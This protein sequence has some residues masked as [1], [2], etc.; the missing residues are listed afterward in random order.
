MAKKKGNQLRLC[1]NFRH[2]NTMKDAYPIPRIDESLAKLG[3]ARL[4]TTLDLGSAFWQVPLRKEDRHKTVF[5]SQMGLLQG[6]RMPFGLCNATATF[7]RLMAN[8]LTSMTQ[9]YENLVMCYVDNVIIATE[10]VDQHLERLDEVLSA[11]EGAGLKCKPSKCSIMRASITYLGRV[12][13]E[14]GIRPD[15]ET[16]EAVKDWWKPRNKEDMQ[17][18]LDFANCCREFI[19]CDSD[20]LHPMQLMIKK[21][22]EYKLTPD[23]ECAFERMKTIL[24]SSPV[25]ALPI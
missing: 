13:D 23:A 6:K 19:R 5:A 10:N 20:T 4:F 7:Q 14:L 12:I 22:N 9:S 16:I 3:Q 18:F 15:P 21:G 2:L 11:I 8:V 17:S 25:L 1:C 24:F